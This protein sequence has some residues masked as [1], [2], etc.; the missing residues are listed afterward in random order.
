M[1]TCP[2]MAPAT[3]VNDS[4]TILRVILSASR[5]AS[6]ASLACRSS[7]VR[8]QVFLEQ[9]QDAL[10]LIRPTRRLNEAVIFRRIYRQLPIFFPQLDQPLRQAHRILEMDIGIRHPVTD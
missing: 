4:T 7:R 1:A 8:L 3:K 5:R 10:V 2:T 6:I 9:I